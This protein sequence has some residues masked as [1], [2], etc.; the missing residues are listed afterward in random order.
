MVL[1][2]SGFLILVAAFLNKETNMMGPDFEI[3]A[4]KWKVKSGSPYTYFN[5]FPSRII[6][7]SEMDVILQSNW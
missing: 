4:R 7:Q 2:H 3:I 6:I 5:L 1:V